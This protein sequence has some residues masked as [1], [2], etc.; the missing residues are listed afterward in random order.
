VTEGYSVS[1]C[2]T[3]PAQRQ[4]SKQTSK[5][6]AATFKQGTDKQTNE[7]DKPDANKQ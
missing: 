3:L 7:A 1:L 6:Q 4:A 5:R 2:G